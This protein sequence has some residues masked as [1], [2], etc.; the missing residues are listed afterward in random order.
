MCGFCFEVGQKYLFFV[1][2][3]NSVDA[4]SSALLDG[5][6][7]TENNSRISWLRDQAGS[8]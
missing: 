5:P 6:G 2:P 3:D 7:L 8:E 1:A 4:F